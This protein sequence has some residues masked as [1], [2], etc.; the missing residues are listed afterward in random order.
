MLLQTAPTRPRSRQQ[1]CTAELLKLREVEEGSFSFV[2]HVT[3]SLLLRLRLCPEPPPARTMRL[4]PLALSVLAAAASAVSASPEL[5]A[6]HLTAGQTAL[7]SGHYLDA[8]RAFTQAFGSSPVLLP[9]SSLHLPRRF[10]NSQTG[11]LSRWYRA[12]QE[13]RDALQKGDL[14]PQPGPEWSCPGRL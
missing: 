12:G 5:A 13:L 14:L 2:R 7:A 6:P 8:S 11:A 9:L 10:T 3:S 1:T 4:L